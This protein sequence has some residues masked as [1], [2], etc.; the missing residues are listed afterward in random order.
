M[1]L[2]CC[3]CNELV[4]PRLTDGEEIYP[5]R[6]DLYKLPFWKCNACGNY[7]GCHHKT[8]D[9]TKPLGSIPT[10]EIRKIRRELHNNIDDV[11]K[12]LKICSRTKIYR[13]ISKHLGR[14][15]HSANIN[16]AKEAEQVM[17]AFSLAL[18]EI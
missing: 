13:L 2:F 6:K 17:D 4:E 18:D 3:G 16:S 9:R 15:Y 7:V 14:A 5:H 8:K 11:W 12:N 10:A 1:I